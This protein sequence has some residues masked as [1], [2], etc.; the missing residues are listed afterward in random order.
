MRTLAW[1]W[2]SASMSCVGRQPPTA[3][4][5]TLPETALHWAVE[6]LPTAMEPFGV[7]PHFVLFAPKSS[8]FIRGET[9]GPAPPAPVIVGLVTWTDGQD[10][11]VLV[12]VDGV[13]WDGG[14]NRFGTWLVERQTDGG[15][16]NLRRAPD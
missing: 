16:V 10:S 5:V 11:G 3:P 14:M 2:L 6:S 4:S 15:L 13:D 12:T 9:G 8:G 1:I 7:N